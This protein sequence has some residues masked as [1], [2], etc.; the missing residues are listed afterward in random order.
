MKSESKDRVPELMDGF[1]AADEMPA[2]VK[3]GNTT[4]WHSLFEALIHSGRRY[5][6]KKYTDKL[7][8][9]RDYASAAQFA[10][11]KYR[12]VVQVHT[13]NGSLC[14]EAICNEVA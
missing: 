4:K 12:G 9:N 8:L 13:R 14:I 3:R 1:M 11:R 6:V 10:H 2:M 7:E 5:A